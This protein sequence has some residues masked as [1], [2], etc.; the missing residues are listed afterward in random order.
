MSD[1]KERNKTCSHPDCQLEIFENNE[2]C[3]LHC[4]KDDW[5]KPDKNG[6]K[7]WSLSKGKIQKF[8]EFFKNELKKDEELHEFVD[9]KF[10]ISYI[11]DSFSKF[12]LEVRNEIINDSQSIKSLNLYNC[13]FLDKVEIDS[14]NFFYSLNFSGCTFENILIINGDIKKLDFCSCFF[15]KGLKLIYLKDVILYIE[16][17]NFKDR[18]YSWLC[19]FGELRVEISNIKY[20]KFFRCELFSKIRLNEVNVDRLSFIKCKFDDDLYCEFHDVNISSLGIDS[21]DNISDAVVFFDVTIHRQFLLKN[22]NLRNY[23]FHNC[24]VSCAYKKF[25]NVAF[26]SNNGFTIFNGIKWGDIAKT[27]DFSTDRDAFRQLKY[28]NEKQGNIIEANKFYSAEMKA[29]KEEIKEERWKT[30]WQDK[31]IFWL[32]NKVS[33]FSQNWILPLIWFFVTG[34]IAFFI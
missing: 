23:E 29:Y 30:H 10:P 6:K 9:I 15:L 19:S 24:D 20:F 7:D 33:N 17:S 5:Y 21:V 28:V 4:E 11:Y 16:G 8:W 34:A 18:I 22:T 13:S 25:K 3:I 31:I 26:Q 32:N 12:K 27:F 14:T 2:K 1:I